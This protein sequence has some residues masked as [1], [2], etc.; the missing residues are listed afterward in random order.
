MLIDI[1]FPFFNIRIQWLVTFLFIIFYIFFHMR[2]FFFS[3]LYGLRFF[4]I[5]HWKVSGWMLCQ[6]MKIK[7]RGKKTELKLKSLEVI[8]K[9]TIF[10]CVMWWSKR[11]Q[12]SRRRRNIWKYLWEKKSIIH[13]YWTFRGPRPGLCA[14]QLAAR[15]HRLTLGL[16]EPSRDSLSV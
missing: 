3:S 10:F 2:H 6:K 16:T 15:S 11:Q 8:D 12:R 7:I 5:F 14:S 4:V 13:H 9:R 1:Y